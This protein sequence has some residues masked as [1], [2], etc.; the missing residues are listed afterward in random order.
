MYLFGYG[1]LININSAQKSF[2]RKLKQDDLIPVKVTGYKKVWNSIE[3]ISFSNKKTN[4]VFL[5]LKK[6]DKSF[7]SGVIIKI[8]E[9]ELIQ[10]KL[11]E[12]NYTCINIKSSDIKL[13]E[14]C[15]A[16]DGEIISFMTTNKDKIAKIGDLNTYIPSKYIDI[17]VDSFDTYDRNFVKEYKECINDLPFE[18][19]K[20]DYSFCDTVQNKIAREGI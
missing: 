8:S 11:R 1:S 7:T 18:I 2:K 5:N 15:S 13:G 9:E 19:K 6:E 14:N 12:K 10:L 4:G 20:G 16:L 17:L 3:Y